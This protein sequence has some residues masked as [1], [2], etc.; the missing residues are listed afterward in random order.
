MKVHGGETVTLYG[1]PAGITYTIVEAA[2]NMFTADK[3]QVTNKITADGITE[4]FTNTRKT[5]PLKVEKIVNGSHSSEDEFHFKVTLSDTS[6]GGAEGKAFGGMTFKNGIAEFTLKGGQSLLAEGLP[7]GITY[8]VEETD[9]NTNGYR[10]V[11]TG[12]TGTICTS[13]KI[14][15]FT[16]T[17]DEGGLIVYKTVESDLD[18]DKSI[19]FEFTVTLKNDDGSTAAVSG[20]YGD[21]KDDSKFTNGVAKITLKDGQ[22]AYAIG[23]PNGLN[24]GVVET[25]N[26]N[27]KITYSGETGT[28]N[29]DKAALAIVKNTRKTGKIE[30][31]KK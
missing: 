28:I 9:A 22:T 25:A 20:E 2:D 6:I 13:E 19:G 27:F 14:A 18:A 16:N 1:L 30:I 3:T 8:T 26:E 5:G 23:L 24:Y 29:K 11:S 4:N 7:V 15:S 12:T 10:T 17:K 21:F 31:S